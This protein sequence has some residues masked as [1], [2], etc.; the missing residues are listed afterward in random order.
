MAAET[1]ETPAKQ[2]TCPVC[3]KR[4][5]DCCYERATLTP[6]GDRVTGSLCDDC[7]Q[8]YEYH[9][10]EVCQLEIPMHDNQPCR[11]LFWS[12]WD[13]WIGAGNYTFDEEVFRAGAGAVCNVIGR[14]WAKRLRKGLVRHNVEVSDCDDS[15]MTFSVEADFRH[16]RACPIELPLYWMDVGYLFRDLEM[17]HDS[18][19]WIGLQWFHSLEPGGATA[20]A[21]ITTAGWISEW[22]A[23]TRR[24]K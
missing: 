13:G 24:T 1:A 10:C 18:D 7:Q 23:A 16:M 4:H 8:E 6:D 15:W 21:D 17:V 3:N 22:L 12:G 20:A 5:S 11:H 2:F 19:L 14:C 9:W